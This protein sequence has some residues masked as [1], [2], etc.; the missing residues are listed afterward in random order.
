MKRISTTCLP[1]ILGTL[2]LLASCSKDAPI[3]PA[4]PS[5]TVQ[6]GP[7]TI[8]TCGTCSSPNSQNTN[9]PSITMDVTPA[10][11]IDKGNNRF[12]FE[13]KPHF[14]KM[15]YELW[16][17]YPTKVEIGTGSKDMLVINQGNT[18]EYRW[19]YLSFMHYEIELQATKGVS[20]PTF[21]L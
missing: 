8:P 2:I 4:P 18:V 7:R 13:L 15:P 21:D 14:G 20:P 9:S 5:G 10:D 1:A 19:C 16:E 3:V 6:T 12:V 11:W 17:Y